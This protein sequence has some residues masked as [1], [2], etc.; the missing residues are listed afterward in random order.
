[1]I[2]AVREWLK[3]QGLRVQLPGSPPG[4][5]LSKKMIDKRNGQEGPRPRW[6][7]GGSSDDQRGGSM[8][9]RLEEGPLSNAVI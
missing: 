6:K 4:P 8:A 7:E 2:P 1:M 3:S 5:R 9:I